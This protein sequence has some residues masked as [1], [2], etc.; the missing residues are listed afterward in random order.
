MSPA[1]RRGRCES[2][3]GDVHRHVSHPR[4]AAPRP[5]RTPTRCTTPSPTW[6]A[7]RRAS[8]LYPAQE[9]ALIELVTGANV[10]PRDAD[11]VRQVAG[12]DRRAL[13]RAG[14]RTAQLLHRADQGAGAREVLRARA[15]SFGADNVGM[16]TGDAAST[17]T[18]RSSAAPPRCWP[19]SRCAR[20]PQADVGLV[21][22][23]EFHFYADPDRGWAWQVPLL[24]LPQAQFLLMSATLGD[25]TLLRARTSPGAPAGRPR[26]VTHG[27]AAR[28][29]CTSPTRSTPLHETIEELLHDR[30]GA[31]LRRALHPG[32]RRSSGRRRCMSVNVCTREREGRDR[33]GASA[34]SAS[35]P[36]S[37]RRCRGWSA[38]G[39]GVHHAGMLPKYRRLVETARPGRAA[40]G[41]LRHRHPRRRHQRA[42]PHR[43]VHRAVAS[44]TAPACGTLQGARVPPDRRPRR[45]RRLR[46][47]RRRRRAGARARR[48]RTSRRSPRPATTRRSAARSCARRPPEG[49]VTWSEH[50]LRPARRRR[51][52][53]A[54]VA[55]SRSP[56]RWCST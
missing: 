10:D 43:A 14:Q 52:R 47:R 48:S 15:T 28:C 30:P 6:A 29:R 3:D 51:A 44:T 26:V 33:R 17:P 4:R 53:A 16:L 38:H 21:V 56:T 11:R 39:I 50:D 36:A 27:R 45:P 35:P 31:G 40:Q 34:A 20:A 2:M 41:H 7:R 8:T 12:R 23:D 22:M 5:R 42:D 37:A 46:H 18:P 19:T 54:D 9:E 55:A 24:E 1:R 13:R 25:V 32:R 49:F